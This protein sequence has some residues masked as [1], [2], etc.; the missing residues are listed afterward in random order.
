MTSARIPKGV[1]APVAT[2]FDERGELDLDKFEE[3]LRFYANSPLD[4]VVILGS[5]GEFS[6]LDI[7]E[8]LRRIERGVKAIDG[9]KVVMAGTGTESTKGTIELTTKAAA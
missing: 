4:G 3:N 1:F 8:R 7:D 9:R 6:W 5:N 2:I